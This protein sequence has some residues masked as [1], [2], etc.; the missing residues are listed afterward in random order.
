VSPASHSSIYDWNVRWK[1]GEGIVVLC[2]ETPNSLVLSLR[3]SVWKLLAVSTLAT[4][5]LAKMGVTRMRSSCLGRM[6][7]MIVRTPPR[8]D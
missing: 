7:M 3:L 8:V 2:G 6:C 1:L 5:R 4:R